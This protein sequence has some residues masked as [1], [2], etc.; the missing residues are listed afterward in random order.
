MFIRGINLED[1]NDSEAH[2]LSVRQS[3]KV[4]ILKAGLLEGVED[5]EM[6][7]RFHAMLTALF[8]QHET[9]QLMDELD[10]P[11]QRFLVY[12][13]VAPSSTGFISVREIG[14]L[15]AKLLYSIRSCVFIPAD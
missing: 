7:E 11:V 5:E 13:S 9:R 4:G 8:F 6:D 15:I 2:G 12:A 14:R 3:E 1:Q 10:C